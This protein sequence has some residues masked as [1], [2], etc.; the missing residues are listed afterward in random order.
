MR[1]LRAAAA[2]PQRRLVIA[3]GRTPVRVHRPWTVTLAP[4]GTATEALL[5]GVAS[6]ART[7][8]A[9]RTRNSPSCTTLAIC[10]PSC[11]KNR[12]VASP[13]PPEAV[14]DLDT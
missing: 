9:L 3:G 7:V 10:R 11:V 6:R 12:P 13:R 14:G 5:T 8:Q 2:Q 1:D 4:A